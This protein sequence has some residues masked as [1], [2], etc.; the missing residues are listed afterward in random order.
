VVEHLFDP[1]YTETSKKRSTQKNTAEIGDRALLYSRHV[2]V[3]QDEAAD[4]LKGTVL[5]WHQRRHAGM[6]HFPAPIV[7]YDERCAFS[8]DD[9]TSLA[10]IDERI[11]T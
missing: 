8:Q 7:V 11:D 6:S 10:T 4:M 2:R 9:H 3:T 1:E 5:R